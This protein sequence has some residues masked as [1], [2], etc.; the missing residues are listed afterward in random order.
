M[1]NGSRWIDLAA[2]MLSMALVGCATT[3]H[4]KGPNGGYSDKRISDS[5]YV[6]SFRG[7]GFA[8]YERVYNFWMY[9]CAELTLSHGYTLF[10]IQPN[11]PVAQQTPAGT[12]PA[13][14]EERGK[15]RAIKAAFFVAPTPFA[16]TATDVSFSATVVM[17]HGP[18]APEIVWALDAQK[19][20]AA[21][22]PFILSD[23]DAQIPEMANLFEPA[24]VAHALIETGGAQARSGAT[25]T[26][27]DGGLA[28]LKNPRSVAEVNDTF[29]R[30]GLVALLSA[31]H[32]YRNLHG[33]DAPGGSYRMNFTVRATGQAANIQT[34]AS[35]FAD[36]DFAALVQAILSRT[37]FGTK[38]VADT[39]VRNFEISFRPLPIPQH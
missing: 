25:P 11:Q 9:R 22:K 14:D 20:Q 5:A 34:T 3:Y 33:A 35:S 29:R 10:S 28:P 36:P 27:A 21:L 30:A 18:L 6:V 37:Y 26:T 23:D 19:I 4:A 2:G 13:T 16:P 24:L 8:S 38:D 7:K 39:D 15:A 1:R 31:Y 12:Q 32:Q 17:Y